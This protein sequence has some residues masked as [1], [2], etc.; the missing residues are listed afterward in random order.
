[1]A[2]FSLI[3][4]NPN[5]CKISEL[6]KCQ[7]YRAAIWKILMTNSFSE[8]SSAVIYFLKSVVHLH[9]YIVNAHVARQ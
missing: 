7:C 1:M 4:S 6:N 8:N 9:I 3:F 5:N 2:M